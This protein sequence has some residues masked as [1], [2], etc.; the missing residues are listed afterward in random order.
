MKLPIYAYGQPV[1][2]KKCRDITKEELKE[3]GNIVEDMFETM[4]N[5]N[6]IGLAAPQIGKDIRL[7][8][9]DTKQVEEE[10]TMKFKGIKKA[11][12]NAQVIEKKGTPYAYEEG[13]LSFPGINGKIERESKVVIKY[14]DEQFEEH[15]EEYDGLNARV[16]LHEY[17]HIDG[18]LFIEKMSPLKL[19]MLKKKLANVKSG[20]VKHDYKMKFYTR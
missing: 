14:L 10:D 2:K 18:I 13:C 6:G 12:I 4:Y 5:A 1:L 20:K 9:V 7:F 16:I 17:D 15:T 11:F 8:I 19:K 3:L